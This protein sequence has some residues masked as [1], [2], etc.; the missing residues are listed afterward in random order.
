M[1][2]PLVDSL[3]HLQE[4]AVHCDQVRRQLESF[5]NE[6]ESLQKKI[7]EQREA[8]TEARDKHRQLEIERKDLEGRI[9]SEEEQSR[10]YRTQQMSV[11]R[12]EE[13]KAFEHEIATCAERISALEDEE[14]EI[15]LRIDEAAAALQQREAQSAEEIKLLEGRIAQLLAAEQEAKESLTE[16]EAKAEEAASNVEGPLLT[17]YRYVSGRVRKPPYVVPIEDKQCQGCYLRISADIESQARQNGF[18]R[19]DNCGRMLYLP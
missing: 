10:K 19:C 13:Y 4:C 5:P 11:K 2:N 17:E 6:R 9:A 7:E 15:L 14:I 3:L 8:V 12:N 1:S 16:A 18:A